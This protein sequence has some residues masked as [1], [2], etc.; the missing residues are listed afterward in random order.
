M[1]STPPPDPLAPPVGAEPPE[2]AEPPVTVPVPAVPPLPPPL[3]SFASGKAGAELHAEA[4]KSSK[5]ARKNRHEN[6]RFG[7][8]RIGSLVMLHLGPSITRFLDDEHERG[9]AKLA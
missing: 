7:A 8:V 5:Q 3:P 4:A 2:P 6:E 1:H 9:P